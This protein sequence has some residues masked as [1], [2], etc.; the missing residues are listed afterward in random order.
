MEAGALIER[1]VVSTMPPA[2][3]YRLSPLGVRFVE[4]V[5]CLYDWGIENAKALDA[6]SPCAGSRRVARHPSQKS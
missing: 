4:P 1:N 6:L 2:V 3:E 5:Q